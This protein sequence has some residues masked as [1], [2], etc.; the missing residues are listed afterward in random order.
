LIDAVSFTILCETSHVARSFFDRLLSDRL[1]ASAQSVERA[2]FTTLKQR[3]AFFLLEELGNTAED[4]LIL[5]H[6][7]VASHIGCTR[8]AVT[9]TLHRF[10]RAGFVSLT[11]GNIE[12][13]DTAGL[14]GLILDDA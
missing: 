9:R 12:I 10:V 7:R 5:T 3:L 6:D 4:I 11:R 14:R 13:L 2:L 8:E 1:F